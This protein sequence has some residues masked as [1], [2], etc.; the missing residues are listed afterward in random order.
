VSGVLPGS[1]VSPFVAQWLPRVTEAIGV[2]LRPSLALDL[3]M[4]EGRH[5]VP[6]AMAGFQTFGVDQ[7]VERLATACRAARERSLTFRA[8]AADLNTYPLPPERFDLLFC[9][10]FL[11]RARWQDLKRAVKPGGFVMYETFTVHQIRLG[12]R[13]SSPD[14]LLEPGELS[15]AFADWDVLFSEEADVPAALARLVARKPGGSGTA[16]ARDERRP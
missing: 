11:L 9:T 5:A 7:S 8:W 6:L 10:R 15:A 14:H 12:R 4:G 2:N 3:A 13:P 1:A 16:A